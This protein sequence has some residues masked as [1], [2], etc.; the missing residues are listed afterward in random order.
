MGIAI[1]VHAD[2]ETPGVIESW[3]QA[4]KHSVCIF[5]P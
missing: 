4:R 5:K 2:F 1:I 3:A